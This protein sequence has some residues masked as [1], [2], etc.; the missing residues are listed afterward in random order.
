MVLCESCSCW[1]HVKCVKISAATAKSTPFVCPFCVKEA[2]TRSQ[3]I[4][5]AFISLLH[6]ALPQIDTLISSLHSTQA[7]SSLASSLLALKDAIAN[8]HSTL[9]ASSSIQLAP[10]T[11]SGTTGS[12]FS[13]NTSESSM[14]TLTSDTPPASEPPLAPSVS[15]PNPTA[16][17]LQPTTSSVPALFLRKGRPARKPP[18]P[19]K[20]KNSKPP[21]LPTPPNLP[22]RPFQPLPSNAYLN[23]PYPSPF[24]PTCITNSLCSPSTLPSCKI[25]L[26]ACRKEIWIGPAAPC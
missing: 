26:Q 21:L 22:A 5:T 1:L 9:S 7:N 10:H 17:T 14:Y 19:P 18:P 12:S 4:F 2:V 15:V 25:L 23:V 11:S 13:A 16:C 20:P 8:T 6:S 24:T 3:L